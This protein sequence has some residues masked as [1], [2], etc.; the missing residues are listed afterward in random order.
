MSRVTVR[1]GV[2]VERQDSELIPFEY[3]MFYCRQRDQGDIESCH[4][5]EWAQQEVDMLSVRK[6]FRPRYMKV[7]ETRR[8]WIHMT[9]SSHC[10]YWGEWDSD[11][12]IHSIKRAK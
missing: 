1:V 6:C 3:S 12:E 9:M 2:L 8:Y 4:I 7:G 11:I 10:D 5:S